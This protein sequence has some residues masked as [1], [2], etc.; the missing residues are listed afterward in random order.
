MKFCESAVAMLFRGFSPQ[1]RTS[2]S[3]DVTTEDG[4][5]WS[6]L[7]F[8]RRLL[9][10]HHATQCI[11]SFSCRAVAPHSVMATSRFPWQLVYPI[12][13]RLEMSI[14]AQNFRLIDLRKTSLT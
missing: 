14:D 7:E 8:K 6:S 13:R 3:S 4:Q 2:T 12:A 1:P 11:E 9:L 10:H 5:D